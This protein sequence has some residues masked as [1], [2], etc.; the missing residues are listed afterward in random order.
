MPMDADLPAAGWVSTVLV[1]IGG[2]VYAI[3]SFVSGTRA[4]LLSHN[5][6]LDKLES[7]VGEHLQRL[8]RKIDDLLLHLAGVRRDD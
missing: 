3:F 2:V 4:Q 7:D 6:R 8:E 5:R 1:T